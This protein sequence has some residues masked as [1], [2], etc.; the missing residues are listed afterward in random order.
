M[1]SPINGTVH[2]LLFIQNLANIQF[3]NIFAKIKHIYYIKHIFANLTTKFTKIK[4][5]PISEAN[6]D[7]YY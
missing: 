5:N 1:A 4:R 2:P 7:P 3:L 6:L